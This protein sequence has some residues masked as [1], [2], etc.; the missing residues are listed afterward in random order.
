MQVAGLGDEE[1]AFGVGLA[2]GPDVRDHLTRHCERNTT[3]N[4]MQRISCGPCRHR[5]CRGR[6]PGHR[7]RRH[8]RRRSADSYRVLVRQGRQ[9][10]FEQPGDVIWVKDT[11]A[12][13]HHATVYWGISSKGESYVVHQCNNCKGAGTWVRCAHPEIPEHEYIAFQAIVMEE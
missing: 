7:T 13:G 1:F 12:D 8:G 2:G 11:L 9:A 3:L 10:C 5:P 6:A 4:T